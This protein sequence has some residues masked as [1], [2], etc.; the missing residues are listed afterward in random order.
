MYINGTFVADTKIAEKH[1]F[2][3][4]SV[5][6]AITTHLKENISMTGIICH[7]SDSMS[8]II[9]HRCNPFFLFYTN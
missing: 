3:N 7:I 9:L 4:Q 2:I 8:F 1:C 5:K 6:Q